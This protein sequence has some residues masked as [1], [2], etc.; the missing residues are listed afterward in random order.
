MR[1]SVLALMMVGAAPAA[2]LGQTLQDQINNVYQAQQAEEAR[3]QAA[4]A[5]QQVAIRREREQELAAQRARLAAAEARQRELAAEAEAD[6]K[7]DQA[8]E[9]K[10]RDLNI[11]R[12]EVDLQEEKGVAAREKDYIDSDLARRAAETDVIKSQADKVRSQADA[13]RNVSSGVKDYLDQSGAAEVK[14]A[15]HGQEPYIRE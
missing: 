4:E 11:Q 12:Q 10:L 15:G 1:L 5:A 2:A 13:N 3:Q 14:G 8:Y 6:K 7:R 9:D